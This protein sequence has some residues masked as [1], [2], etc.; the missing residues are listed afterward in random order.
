MV[1]NIFQFLTAV[2]TGWKCATYREEK[3]LRRGWDSSMRKIVTGWHA[4]NY[5]INPCRARGWEITL[6]TLITLFAV[7]LHFVWSHFG[8][9]Y[10][11]IYYSLLPLLVCLRAGLMPW[12]SY[13]P[14]STFPNSIELT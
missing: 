12:Q 14:M 13:T 10:N 8:R 3:R 4:S 9:I 11:A 2:V 5:N 6:F 1:A 7:T